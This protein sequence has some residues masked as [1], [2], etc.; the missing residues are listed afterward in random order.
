MVLTL[1]NLHWID[2]GVFKADW[3]DK[4]KFHGTLRAAFIKEGAFKKGREVDKKKSIPGRG[5]NMYKVPEPD[6][7][8]ASLRNWEQTG[9]AEPR[10]Q[11][12]VAGGEVAKAMTEGNCYENY[13][14]GVVI[15]HRIE[16]RWTTFFLPQQQ[17][18]HLLRVHCTMLFLLL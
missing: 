1:R 6:K 12:G 5:N 2:T 13:R 17:H 15:T 10:D 4:W 8:L 14:I 16:G 7:S 3:Q 18:P 11:K 9:A